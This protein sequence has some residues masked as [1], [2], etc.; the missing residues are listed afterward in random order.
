MFSKTVQPPNITAC[1]WG[2]LNGESN[3]VIC[4]KNLNKKREMAS[5]T[6][7]MT[8]VVVCQLVER[9][10]LCPQTTYLQ[11]S[12]KSSTYQGTSANL[13][14]GD[15]L[16]VWDLLHGLMLPSGNDA[17]SCLSENFGIYL[18]YETF[19]RKTGSNNTIALP[20]KGCLNYFIDEMNEC[21]KKLKLKHTIY[22]NAHGLPNDL[23][24][25]TV[26]DLCKLSSFAMK[27]EMMSEIVQKKYYKVFIKNKFGKS[28]E[29]DW[30]NLNRML[31]VEGFIGLKTG[32]T[33]PA[34]ACLSSV[35]KTEKLHLIF[36]VLGCESK[37]E[38]FD[39]TE[40]LLNWIKCKISP[41][42][43]KF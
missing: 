35:Y 38:R 33:A 11:I 34:G 40:R 29:M 20:K 2:I 24:K 43:L 4:G 30:I 19:E 25:S 41:S 42:F 36:V 21:A 26:F 31:E 23:N 17:A 39:D 28:R 13:L 15:I 7:I 37:D 1:C 14:E 10:K 27:N 22:S 12:K 5:L 3:Q 6:K 16:S 32:V 18:Y 8:A 9:M